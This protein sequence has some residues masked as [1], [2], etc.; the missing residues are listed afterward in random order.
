MFEF[1]PARLA[2][3]V[4]KAFIS[5]W[6][7][8]HARSSFCVRGCRKREARGKQRPSGKLKSMTLSGQS[9]KSQEQTRW[10]LKGK[11]KV[12][13]LTASRISLSPCSSSEDAVNPKKTSIEMAMCPPNRLWKKG[14]DNLQLNL[15][16]KGCAC[17]RTCSRTILIAHQRTRKDK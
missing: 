16:K 6:R 9:S 2:L 8:L 10:G 17:P 5:A 1:H 11:V 3:S 12:E 14:E 7:S 13:A 4:V 15:L